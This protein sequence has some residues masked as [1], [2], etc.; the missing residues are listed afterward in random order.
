MSDVQ[1]IFNNISAKQKDESLDDLVDELQRVEDLMHVDKRPVASANYREYKRRIEAKIARAKQMGQTSERQI[2][3][4]KENEVRELTASK[5][6]RLADKSENVIDTNRSISFYGT[7][8]T[9]PKEL[10]DLAEIMGRRNL[11]LRG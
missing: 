8:T 10:Q 2:R 3:A 6:P 1:W 7:S 9:I 4:Q 11:G 5:A